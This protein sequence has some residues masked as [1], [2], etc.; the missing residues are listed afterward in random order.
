MITQVEVTEMEDT[1]KVEIEEMRKKMVDATN[2]ASLIIMGLNK[3][4]SDL[5][6]NQQSS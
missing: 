6:V 3:E 1:K 2:E 5:E 4:L